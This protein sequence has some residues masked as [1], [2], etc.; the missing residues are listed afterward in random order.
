MAVEVK[1]KKWGNSM[2]IILPNGLIKKR[3]IEENDTLMIEVVKEAD[4]T[5]VFNSI[6]KNKISGQK[7]KDMVKKGWEK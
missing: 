2:G 6:K 1:V 4:L 3:N 7:F 5:D